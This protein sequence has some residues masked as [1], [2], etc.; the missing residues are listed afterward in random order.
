MRHRG[1]ADHHVLS[2]C[3]TSTITRAHQEL[4][5]TREHY[6]PDEAIFV[7]MPRPIDVDYALAN[8]IPVELHDGSRVVLRKLGRGYDPTDAPAAT[9][10]SKASW[11]QN[12]YVTDYPHQ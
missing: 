2:P 12:E 6:H 11:K 3:V 5:I 9:I 4:H 1:F 10:S 7:P 8:S